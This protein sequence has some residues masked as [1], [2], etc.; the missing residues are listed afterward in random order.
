MQTWPY[1]CLIWT[2]PMDPTALRKSLK[3]H[4]IQEPSKI[5]PNFFFFHSQNQAFASFIFTLGGKHTISSL[6]AQQVF[7]QHKMFSC[8]P[9]E[10]LPFKIKL[11]C[12]FSDLVTLRICSHFSFVLRNFTSLFTSLEYTFLILMRYIYFLLLIFETQNAA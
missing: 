3:C 12:V 5:W 4:S 10:F 2:L 1:P 6:L 9:G 7:S 8:L 11:N